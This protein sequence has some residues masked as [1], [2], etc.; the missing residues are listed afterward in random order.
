[1]KDVPVIDQPKWPAYDAQPTPA[2]MSFRLVWTAT[3]EKVAYENPT[4]QF[5][6][7]G[8]RAT[9]QLEASVEVPAIGFTWKSDPLSTSHANFAVIG[10]EVNG[11]YYAPPPPAS[12]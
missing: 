11:R 9:A 12:K 2:R 5:R 1:M 4:Q 7:T 3:D 10:E 6:I 8:F